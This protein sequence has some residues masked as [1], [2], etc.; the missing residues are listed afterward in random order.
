MSVTPLPVTPDAPSAPEPSE[1]GGFGPKG[2]I[3]G[4]VLGPLLAVGL[5]F[6]GAPEGLSS[7][8]WIVVSLAAL[9]LVWWVTEAVPISATALVPLVGLP[10]FGVT[11]AGDAAAP[12]ADPILFLFIGG[13][14]IA[15]AI[16]RWNL[17]A[18]IALG[19][20]SAVGTNPAAL[21]GGFILAAA[22][23]SMWISNTATTLML[24]PI[25]VAVAA[26][27]A[28]QRGE[29]DPALGAGLVLGVAY[30]A[31]IGGMGT[32]VGSPTNLIAMGFL[33]RN[34]IA[35]SFGQWMTLGVPVILLTLPVLWFLTTRGLKKTTREEA[36]QG[37]EV[38]R[39]ALADL[40]PMSRAEVRVGLVFA[41]VAVAWMTREILLVKL[42]GLGK[43]TDMS[44]AVAG[45]LALF[46]LPSG[47]RTPGRERLLDWPTAE[48][49]PWGIVVLFG[50]GLSLA[51]AMESSGLSAWLGTEMEAL[52]GL[53]FW[54]VLGV[55][56][57][58]TLVA[59]ELM[60]NVATL[61][62]MLPVVAAF[63]AAL[64]VNPLL[65]VFPVSIA[66]SL[67]FM[68]PIATAPN[69]IAYAT[70]LPSLKR[71]LWTGFLLNAAGIA[72]IWAVNTTLASQVL[73]G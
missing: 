34:G 71:M 67:G 15:K 70:G 49:I 55:L 56:L 42:P 54:I 33:E 22:L 4:L 9:M 44:I 30:A 72:A 18:R 12:Y 66:A 38:V 64:G 6:F 68:L 2:R 37:R 8:A 36:A 69:A 58:V 29:A 53:E 1:G 47:D 16:E 21:I 59:T 32:P 27:M 40:G 17:H 39:G 10:L 19:V 48:R 7:Q 5:Q 62:A 60:S 14:M 25:A 24:T 52:R 26:A 57:V 13:F 31:S 50:G 20:A 43:L 35:L 3:A 63:A 28:R 23:I 65:L 51:G 45:A 46:L 61:T 11:S 41:A 73:G